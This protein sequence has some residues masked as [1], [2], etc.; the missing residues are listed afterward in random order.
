MSFVRFFLTLLLLYPSFSRAEKTEIEFWH[1]F[2]G[3]LEEKLSQLVKQFNDANKD[4]KVKLV[5]KGNYT[6]TLNA[7]IAAYRGGKQPHLL[8]VFEVGTQTMMS[9]EVIYPV[10]DLMKDTGHAV[11]W[12]DFLKPVLSYYQDKNGKLASMPFNSSSPIFYYNLDLMEKAKIKNPPKTWQQYFRDSEAL[13]KA[14]VPCGGA[15]GWQPWILVENFCAIHDLPFASREN[16]TL[17]V[18]TELQFDHPAVRT[19]LEALQKLLPSHAFVYEGR[20]SDP[21]VA[22]TNGR[23]A[24]YMDSSGNITTFQQAAKFPWAAAPMP[25]NEDT[26]KPQNSIIGGASIWV[27]RGHKPEHYKAAGA[28]FAFLSQPDTQIWWHKATGYLPIT[29]TAYQK[30]KKEGYYKKEPAQEVAVLQLL[31]AKPNANSR[32]IRLGYF[33]QIR[34]IMDEEM[35]KIWSGKSSAET[36][37]HSAVER[38][39]KVLRHYQRTQ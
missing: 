1:A 26:K 19:N 31:R 17:G 28:F 5:G 11:N 29:Q 30:L 36:A 34:E 37:L 2:N 8:Q 13:V 20:R 3:D 39:N 9:S 15:I 21:L 16:G 23:C 10:Q 35:E 27:F 24:Y 33:M 14:G 22:F 18:D 38:G 7:A 25:Y 12:D 6:E 4:Y 32:G